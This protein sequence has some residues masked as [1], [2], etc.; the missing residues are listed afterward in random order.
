MNHSSASAVFATIEDYAAL[1]ISKFFKAD[2]RQWVV[3]RGVS[4]VLV[5]NEMKS[6][7]RY[8]NRIKNDCN[9]VWSLWGFNYPLQ[10]HRPHH[11]I[12]IVRSPHI[13]FLRI[14]APIIT[15]YQR[16]LLP[17]LTG[18]IV[19]IVIIID[20]GGGFFSL[21]CCDDRWLFSSVILLVVLI[22]F[23][24]R[25]CIFSRVLCCNSTALYRVKHFEALS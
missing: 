7:T 23:V 1:Y 8:C 16:P 19:S 12:T 13:F 21:C 3:P 2:V 5:Q 14:I 25:C 24:S 22:N 17:T 4:T 10:H 18:D 9:G 6:Y 11:Q 15:I 20:V